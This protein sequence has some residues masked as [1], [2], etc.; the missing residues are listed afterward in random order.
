MNNLPVEAYGSL[1]NDVSTLWS[2]L[3]HS[4]SVISPNVLSGGRALLFEMHN[5]LPVPDVNSSYEDILNFK[6]IRRDELLALRGEM[7]QMYQ[8]I[9]NSEDIEHAKSMNFTKLEKA[10]IDMQKVGEEKWT[11][12]LRKNLSCEIDFERLLEWNV[13]CIDSPILGVAFGALSCFRFDL[14]GF[15]FG[16]GLPERLVP[17]K[18]VIEANKKLR[19]QSVAP[20]KKKPLQG[21]DVS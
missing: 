6:N 3:D 1:S 12:K 14:S 4:P 5:V 17:Y 11:E 13:V 15:V 19:L 20:S 16:D 2:Y 8:E 21:R 10:L 18:Y 7:D 9:I